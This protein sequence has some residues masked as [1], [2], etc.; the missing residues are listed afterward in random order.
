MQHPA[1]KGFKLRHRERATSSQ[2]WSCP[3]RRAA[4]RV[5]PGL[6]ALAARSRHASPPGA[7]LFQPQPGKEKIA[8]GQGTSKGPPRLT[9]AVRDTWTRAGPPARSNSTLTRP[10]L[11]RIWLFFQYQP[12]APFP[13][14]CCSAPRE[15][16]GNLCMQPD[17]FVLVGSNAAGSKAEPRVLL[18]FKHCFQHA[19]GHP[20]PVRARVGRPP[21]TA[22]G[23]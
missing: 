5:Q 8:S 12:H 16:Q 18:M 4:L 13:P 15:G 6:G 22:D 17:W 21:N 1:P 9:R 19:H 10:I 3:P 14:G 20:V 2:G 11:L 23:L 7:A